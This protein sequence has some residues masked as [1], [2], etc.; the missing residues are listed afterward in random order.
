MSL[1]KITI[2]KQKVQDISVRATLHVLFCI[3]LILNSDNEDEIIKDYIAFNERRG[4][5]MEKDEF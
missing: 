3:S 1:R 5:K 4:R 2:R